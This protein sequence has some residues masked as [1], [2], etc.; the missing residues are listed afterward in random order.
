VIFPFPKEFSKIITQP[1]YKYIYLLE[2]SNNRI[3]VINKEGKLI[4]QFINN[5]LKELKDFC[6]D[7]F[8]KNI[9]LLD[10]TKIYQLKL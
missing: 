4:R 8:E 5:E 3:I 2:P 10:G 6:L 9:Y 7:P 1:Q